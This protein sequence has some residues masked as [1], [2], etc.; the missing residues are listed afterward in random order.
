MI[1]LWNKTCRLGKYI[2]KRNEADE[3]I[4]VIEFNDEE[5]YCNKK[6]IRMSEFYQAQNSKYKPEITLEIRKADLEEYS[7]DE[8]PFFVEYEGKTYSLIRSYEPSE[9]I[10]E[11][12]LHR[13]IFYA[14]T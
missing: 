3:Q 10:V 1:I 11:L 13:G 12:V 5:I 2:S 4:E 6:S 7:D 14:S 9:D 8:K